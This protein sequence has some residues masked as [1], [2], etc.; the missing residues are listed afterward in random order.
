MPAETAA[1]PAETAAPIENVAASAAYRELIER[2][3]T[4]IHESQ[5]RAARAVNSELVALYW[6]IGCDILQQQR[7][8]GWGDDVVGR[9]ARDLALET[10]AV[11]GF[12]RRN[13]FY[14]RRFAAL[15]PDPKTLQTSSA[16]I[17]WSHHQALLD[18]CGEDR[19]LYA[20]YALTAAEQ[21]WSV[22]QLRGQIALALHRRVG[23][24][25][26]NF[27]ATLAPADAQCALAT[28]KDPY[29]FDFL[30][31]GREVRE[32]QLEQA[33]LDDVQRFLL[34][35][36]AGFAFYGRQHAL[37]VGRREFFVDLLFY[38]HAIR[39]FVVV[40]LKVGPFEAEYVSK[41]DV[42]LSAVDEQLR[43]GDDRESV[44][45]I[46]C[47]ERDETVAELALRRVYAPI[48]ISTWRAG[49]PPRLRPGAANT[50]A[51][52]ANAEHREAGADVAELAQLEDLRARLAERIAH[53]APA[54]RAGR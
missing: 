27:H 2:L 50:E 20:W 37:L 1:Q 13:L 31:L 15:W 5:A 25:V 53:R 44:G 40:E 9:I 32:R 7:R 48:A 54:L 10:G 6:S 33:L 41:M 4:R 52:A 42:Y 21:H 8:A 39:R 30:E 47:T 19:E 16:Q 18:A 34:E 14:M 29:V 12:S 3:R 45:I 46:L 17:G 43:C 51:P 36:G 26:S 35:L 49:L 23:R 22:R 24:A 28:V 11:R 38:H